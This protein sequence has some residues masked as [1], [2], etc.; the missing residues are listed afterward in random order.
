MKMYTL[1]VKFGTYD[2]QSGE[3]TYGKYAMDC[4]VQPAMLDGA[5]AVARSALEQ[6]KPVVEQNGVSSIEIESVV[7]TETHAEYTMTWKDTINDKTHR[8]YCIV[9]EKPE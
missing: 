5:G 2:S 9:D 3:F 6:N 8:A 1:K 4:T 7:D